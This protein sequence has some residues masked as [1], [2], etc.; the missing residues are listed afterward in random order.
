M[1]TATI[2]YSLLTY[3]HVQ[4]LNGLCGFGVQVRP[5]ADSVLFLHAQ[6]LCMT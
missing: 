3:N 6:G 5:F 4:P 2:M 1:N